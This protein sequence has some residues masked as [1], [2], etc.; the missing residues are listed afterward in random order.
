MEGRQQ[1]M[2]EQGKTFVF[3]TRA[4]MEAIHAS[5]D[6]DKILIQ[7]NL[8]NPLIRQLISLARDYKIPMQRVPVQKLN[9]YT[10][11]NH[12]G[13]VCLLSAIGYA[14]LD[15]IISQ[16]FSEGRSPLIVLLDRITDVR[17]LG[18]IARSADAAAADALVT[19]LTGQAQITPEAIKASAGALNHLPV[20]RVSKLNTAI[21]DLQHSGIQVVACTEKAEQTMYQAD[22][23]I[24]TAILMGSERDGITP[25]L[26]A[27]CDQT[28][29]IP[30]AGKISSLNV[31]VATALIL[32]EC[33]RQRLSL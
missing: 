28:V 12:Q 14:S 10:R 26:L 6:I 31:S 15:H 13:V 5:Q 8:N 29:K 7:K 3:G 17:N 33:V 27:S 18:A 23:K 21:K 25:A 1:P 16:A 2:T 11:K 20:C 22:F 32:F 24:P 19:P 4:V 30:M 9:R